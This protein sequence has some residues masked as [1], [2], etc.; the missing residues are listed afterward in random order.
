MST[1]VG[2]GDVELSWLDIIPADLTT[3]ATLAVDKPDGTS[4]VVPVSGGPLLPIENSPDTRQRWTADTPIIY[5]LPGKWVLRWTVTGTGQGTENLAVYVI[6]SPVAGGPTWT[7][8]RSRVANYVPHRTLERSITSTVESEDTYALSFTSNTIPSGVQMDRLIADGVAWVGSRVYPMNVRVQ[9]AA[10][11]VVSLYA[12]AAC[13]RGY[14]MDDQSL[15]RANDLEKRM[16]MLL[17]DL[18]LTND[19]ANTGDGVASF[20]PAV[21]PQWSFPPPDP[22]FDD[23]RYF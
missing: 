16:D 13:E 12:A 6:A 1:D 21:M 23:S 2:V 18:I 9:A 14:P 8:G 22:R 17:A 10:A 20:P 3:Q 19:V 5:S 15:Q 7:P 11:V 4:S